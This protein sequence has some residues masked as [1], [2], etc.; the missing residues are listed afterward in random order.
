MEEKKKR[1]RPPKAL[2]ASKTTGKR[3]SVGRPKG[4]TAIMNE[5]KA[6]L[7][8]SPN[9]EK[10]IQTIFSVAMDPDHKHWP[11]AMRFIGDRAIP[12]HM[13]DEKE[14]GSK[15]IVQINLQGFG[16]TPVIDDVTDVEVR[17]D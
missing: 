16:N 8:A 7:L 17:D 11:A 13:F 6:R 15:P 9:S 10:V 5:Y 12:M 14:R 1:G 4:D 2:V 3:N